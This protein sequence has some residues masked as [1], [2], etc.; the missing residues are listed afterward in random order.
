M[1]CPGKSAGVQFGDASKG[2]HTKAKP[3][4]IRLSEMSS[5]LGCACKLRP[6]ALEEVLGNLTYSIE[7]P[8]MLVGKETADDAVVVKIV[9]E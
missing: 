1:Q 4:E 3:D 8:C 7:D 2:E 6:Q 9:C 5:G